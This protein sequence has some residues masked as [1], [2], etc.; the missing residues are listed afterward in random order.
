M[1]I[2]RSRSES[3]WFS[4]TSNTIIYPLEKTGGQGTNVRWDNGGDCK[5]VSEGQI[6]SWECIRWSAIILK[7]KGS[8]L[9][10]CINLSCFKANSVGKLHL[11]TGGTIS[12]QIYL[13]LLIPHFLW[14]SY[15]EYQTSHLSHL[16]WLAPCCGLNQD[17]ALK[18]CRRPQ[19]ILW[20]LQVIHNL[21]Y[22]IAT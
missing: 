11:L 13:S 22:G 8:L 10:I 7:P 4:F 19:N 18:F 16:T 9:M 5:T 15:H 21:N 2:P 14:G 6:L 20:A 12:G 17:K 1:K 3:V